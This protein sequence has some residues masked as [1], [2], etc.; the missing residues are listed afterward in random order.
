MLMINAVFARA[1]GRLQC[2]N[3]F[4]G[5]FGNQSFADAMQSLCVPRQ[6]VAQ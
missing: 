4:G 3:G 1:Q 6:V 5:D 2:A